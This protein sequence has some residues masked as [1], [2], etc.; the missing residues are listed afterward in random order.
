MYAIFEIKEQLLFEIQKTLKT[1]HFPEIIKLETPS[2]PNLGDLSFPCFLYCKQSKKTPKDTAEMIAEKLQKPSFIK[3]IQV[4]G[5]YVNFWFDNQIILEKTILTILKKEKEYGIL[6]KKNKKIIVEHTSANPNGPLHVGRARNPII[7]DTIARLMKAAGYNVETQFYLDDLGKQ[8]AILT[9]A[10]HHLDENELSE[11]TSNKPDHH[12][13][14]YYQKAYDLMNEDDTILKKI[15]ALVH[16][17]EL[18]DEKA[19][20]LGKKAYEPVLAGISES[21]ANINISLDTFIPE[22]T[23]VKDGSVN[24]V[25]KKLKNTSYCQEENSALYLDLESFGI[26][27]R[28]TK[29][30]ITRSNGTS[31]YATRDIAYHLW[32]NNHADMLINI[33]G[34]DHKLESK[35]V[36]IALDLLNAEKKPVPV[37]YSFVSLPGGKMSTRRGRVVYLDDLIEESKDRAYDEVKKR[38]GNDLEESSMRKIANI[39]GIGSLRYNII[40]VQPEKDIAFKWEEALNFEGNTAPFIQY[41]I[42]RC[43]SI[44]RKEAIDKKTIVKS[45]DLSLLTHDSEIKLGK[46]LAHFPLIIDE[47]AHSFKPHLITQYLFETASLFNQF[48]RDCPVISAESENLKQSRLAFVL[49]TKI[50][51]ENGLTLLGI[52]TLDEM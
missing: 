31:L 5:G 46:Q 8:V 12:A 47:A 25:I 23:F 30:F 37:F 50:V 6:S 11:K 10:F 27:G 42:A 26:K 51:L 29:F 15:D 17:S 7:G 22:S 36:E 1:L 38:R 33:L 2:D 18:G 49:S 44:L 34:E 24:D 9:W 39:V 20:A 16:Q 19:I 40:K 28:S 21:L 13:V 43:A 3:N 4:N 41:A 35:Q 32:K 48:Y 14:R 52:E 45:C